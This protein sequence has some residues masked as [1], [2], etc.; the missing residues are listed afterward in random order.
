MGGHGDGGMGIVFLWSRVSG[1]ATI[2][3]VSFSPD[4]HELFQMLRML[5][6]P[7]LSC[8]VLGGAVL[9]FMADHRSYALCMVIGSVIFLIL[10]LANGVM[11]FPNLGI[12]TRGEI[13]HDRVQKYFL[14]MGAVDIVG[15]ILF[16]YGLLM[17]GIVRFKL[18]RNPDFRRE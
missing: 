3:A 15:R 11:W 2:R 17:F 5:V 1:S 7:L 6:G 18:S 12:L 10:Q 14:Y 9:L 8:V 13:D 4:L 16:G